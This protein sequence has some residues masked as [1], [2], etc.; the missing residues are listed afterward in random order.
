MIYFRLRY[1][2]KS[3]GIYSENLIRFEMPALVSVELRRLTDAELRKN[4]GQ[5]DLLCTAVLQKP[6]TRKI[7]LWLANPEELQPPGFS[8]FA[9]EAHL[10]C[11]TLRFV[12]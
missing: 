4:Y 12:P 5:D 7:G 3:L 2:V 11:Q 1:I 9:H 10:L 6:P 8:D